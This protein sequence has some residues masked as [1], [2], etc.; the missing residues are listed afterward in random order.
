MFFALNTFLWQPRFE[1]AD[2][3]LLEHVVSLGGDMVEIQCPDLRGFPVAAVADELRRL[4]IGCTLS[5]SSRDQERCLIAAD[6]SARRAGIDDL[7]HAIGVARDL[8]ASIICGP[9]YAPAWWFTGARATADQWRWAI[10]GFAVLAEDLARAGVTLAVEPINR[11]E[12]FFLNT[13]A[14]GVRLCEEIGCDRI[15]LL[16]DTGHMAI[17]EKDPVAAIRASAR[18]L[19]H[20]HLPENDRGIPGTGTIDWPSLFAALVDIGYTGGCAI[21][22]FPFPDP[23]FAMA[24]RTWRDLAPSVD[25]LAR[26]GLTFLRHS[27]AAA[28]LKRRA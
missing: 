2:L 5:T 25:A 18:W 8:G 21:E 28:L 24:T 10:E 17:E 4:G 14:Q 20:L 11:F 15:G 16:L 19:R 23:R 3:S 13:A 26:D 9:L 6:A 12:T 27:H 7:R 22:S 1:K